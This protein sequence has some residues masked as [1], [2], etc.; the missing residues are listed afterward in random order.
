MVDEERFVDL[1]SGEVWRREKL[2]KQPQSP[3]F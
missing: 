1:E 3:A 2:N